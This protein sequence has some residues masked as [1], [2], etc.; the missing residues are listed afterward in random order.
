MA[1]VPR[2]RIW[3]YQFSFAG[4][5]IRELSRSTSKTIAKSAEQERGRELEAGY[6]DLKEVRQNRITAPAR[7]TE[8]FRNSTPSSGYGEN[9]G[10]STSTGGTE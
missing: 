3:W 7:M 8:T 2:G 1:L 4:R 5:M 9:R 6:N 10:T